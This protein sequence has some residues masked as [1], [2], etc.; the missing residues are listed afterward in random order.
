MLLIITL[1]LIIVVI[2]ISYELGMLFM[3][4]TGD[5]GYR[6]LLAPFLS[7]FFVI[8]TSL[9]LVSCF[10]KQDWVDK[11]RLFC[12]SSILLFFFL[13]FEE[14][15]LLNMDLTHDI[16]PHVL[17]FVL[18]VLYF[19]FLFLLLK[20]RYWKKLIGFFLIYF[21]ISLMSWFSDPIRNSIL[22]DLFIAPGLFF[23]LPALVF[24]PL[25]FYL[26]G[27]EWQIRTL[28]LY[29]ILLSAIA[30]VIFT[31]VGIRLYS[32]QLVVFISLIFITYSFFILKIFW[33]K[34]KWLEKVCA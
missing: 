14:I 22:R 19:F 25:I 20:R 5:T 4:F 24:S 16:E 29:N 7:M 12:V 32:L 6:V 13:V 2:L 21:F 15:A 30:I 23:I 3:F 33:R 17:V 8:L 31:T 27:K 34:G 18:S 10:H 11:I 9:F 26:R 1:S 28:L